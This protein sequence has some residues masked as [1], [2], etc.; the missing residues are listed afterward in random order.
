MLKIRYALI[1]A[2]ACVATLMG[3]VVRHYRFEKVPQIQEKLQSNVLTV[4]NVSFALGFGILV[5]VQMELS[6]ITPPVGLYLFSIAGMVKD[7]GI[8]VGD[9]FRGVM[10]FCF[11]CLL[12]SIILWAYPP[13]TMYLVQLMR[14]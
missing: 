2:A 10:P 5:I 6:N 7:R 9:V 1:A 11:T 12:F 3:I 14:Q 13:I 8:T 4:I